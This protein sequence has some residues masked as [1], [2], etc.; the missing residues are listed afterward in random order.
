MKFAYSGLEG[1][2][3]LSNLHQ[4][5]LE[6]N[7]Q[8]ECGKAAKSAAVANYSMLMG[9][10]VWKEQTIILSYLHQPPLEGNLQD[11]CGKAVKSAVVASYSMLMVNQYTCNGTESSVNQ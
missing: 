11:K 10:R 8:Y 5:P 4:P 6:R 9:Y 7:L 3:I 2:I 1:T